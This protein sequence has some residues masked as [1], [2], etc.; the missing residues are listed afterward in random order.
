[1]YTLHSR[2]AFLDRDGNICTSGCRFAQTVVELNKVDWSLTKISLTKW[3]KI[4]EFVKL[5]EWLVSCHSVRV[6]SM[7]AKQWSTENVWY[8]WHAGSL[9]VFTFLS[10]ILFPSL[11]G[12]DQTTEI[13][14]YLL[15]STACRRHRDSALLR[16]ATC[17]RTSPAVE[18]WQSLL[19][20]DTSTLLLPT[21]S[22][23]CPIRTVTPV[24][25]MTFIVVK[26]VQKMCSCQAE[27]AIFLLCSW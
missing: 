14:A 3:Y 24:W 10:R 6:F 12:T 2:H 8:E 15:H 16:T 1:M 27:Q 23:D 21:L 9:S 5:K 26:C 17:F 25:V 4:V 22:T 11:N 13:R 18:H 7:T 20:A 19:V